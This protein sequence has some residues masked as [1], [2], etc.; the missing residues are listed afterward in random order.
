MAPN[1]GPVGQAPYT[2][3]FWRPNIN[4]A[5]TKSQRDFRFMKDVL[6]PVARDLVPKERWGR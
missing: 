4:I 2:W 1:W 5:M 6:K 3:P